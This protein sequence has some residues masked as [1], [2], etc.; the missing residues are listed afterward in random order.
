MR[1]PV[2]V[3]LQPQVQ[4]VLQIL[5]SLVQLLAKDDGVKFLLDGP[6]EPF[7]DA[8]GLRAAHLGFG[9]LNAFN[10]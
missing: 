10:A 6:V 7:S 4:V 2:V 8:V 3:V 9:V 1:P 5:Q